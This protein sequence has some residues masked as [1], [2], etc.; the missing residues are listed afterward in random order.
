MSILYS[1]ANTT[2]IKHP[3]LILEFFA[4]KKIDLF[5]GHS[6]KDK[7]LYARKIIRTTE[8]S[9]EPLTDRQQGILGDLKAFVNKQDPLEKLKLSTGS[10]ASLLT[11]PT[12]D[13]LRNPWPPTEPDDSNP[14]PWL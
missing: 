7:S 11:I 1:V 10:T 6:D 14:L 4:L 2:Q 13:D 3:I 5:E 9:E 12:I 8:R